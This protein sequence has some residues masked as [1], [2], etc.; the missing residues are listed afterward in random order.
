MTI[1]RIS[2]GR[3]GYMNA[4][5][6]IKLEAQRFAGN[7][8][9]V[10]R[11]IGVSATGAL[12]TQ[13]ITPDI[14]DR[15]GG[16][17][18]YDTYEA[19]ED[20]LY[21]ISDILD[22]GSRRYATTVSLD[23]QEI[24]ELTKSEKVEM[25]NKY[26]QDEMVIVRETERSREERL[27]EA[28]AIWMEITAERAGLMELV[29]DGDLIAYPEFS[30]IPDAA[31]LVKIMQEP[32]FDR[33]RFVMITAAPTHFVVSSPVFSK[34][35]TPDLV[36]AQARTIIAERQAKL[37]DAKNQADEAGW[38]E[39]KGSEKQVKWAQMIRAKVAAK[40]PTIKA[41]KTAKNA[42]YWIDN[43]RSVQ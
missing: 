3:H 1:N 10:D 32:N 15:S 35:A 4:E 20:G 11:I 28:Q 24:E 21:V 36:F 31:T 23:D 34:A 14:S 2:L 38:P 29:H 18:G 33:F 30:V 40:D 26:F 19:L 43:H 22:T 12:R 5:G 16:G 25:L 27:A 39:L 9:T 8:P 17:N 13:R 7:R 37:E 41:L 42:K 6:D